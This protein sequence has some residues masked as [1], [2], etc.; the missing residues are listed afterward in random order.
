MINISKDADTERA[1]T[2]DGDTMKDVVEQ[3]NVI[4]D[5]LRYSM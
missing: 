3:I 2:M 4:R 1:D 5:C